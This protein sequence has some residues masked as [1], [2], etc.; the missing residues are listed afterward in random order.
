M[1]SNGKAVCCSAD[2]EATQELR[3]V[4]VRRK[5]MRGFIQARALII[6]LLFLLIGCALH[7]RSYRPGSSWE[8]MIF[9]R[10]DRNIFPDDVRNKFSVYHDTLLVWPGIVQN[11]AMV[12]REDNIEIQ[13]VL[14]HHY[15]DWME[16]FTFHRKKICL[17]PEGEGLFKIS[18][19]VTKDSDIKEMENA[20]SAGNLVI[21]YGTPER[22]NEDG[23]I[24]LRTAYL[25]EI[26]KKWYSTDVLNYGRPRRDAT[27]DRA[28]SQ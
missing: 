28:I 5:E 9:D 2:R 16:D 13:F 18:W 21:V 1:Q 19:S 6:S 3:C 22:I 11:S 12:E 4:I 27:S 14:E 15:Y 23:S 17:S 26:D 25:R 24:T 8:K 7:T 10:A 20:T